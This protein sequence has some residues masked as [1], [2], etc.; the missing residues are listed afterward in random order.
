MCPCFEGHANIIFQHDGS[1]SQ[2]GTVMRQPLITQSR[3]GRSSWPPRSPDLTPLDFWC[4]GWRY[5]KYNLYSSN[6][7]LLQQFLGR[8]SESVAAV[9]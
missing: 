4:V 9:T 2:L 6:V 7:V 5:L 1:P 3:G 8:I